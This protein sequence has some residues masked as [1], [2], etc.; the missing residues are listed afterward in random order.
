MAPTTP[1]KRKAESSQDSD[2]VAS[3]PMKKIHITQPKTEEKNSDQKIDIFI[4][5]RDLRIQDNLGLL[6]LFTKNIKNQT[7]PISEINSES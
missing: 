1:K 6:K 2:D 4:F 5:R 3:S 7:Y